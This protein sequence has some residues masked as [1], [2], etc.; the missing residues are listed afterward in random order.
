MLW[1]WLPVM[2]FEECWGSGM[3]L[4]TCWLRLIGWERSCCCRWLLRVGRRFA[5]AQHYLHSKDLNQNAN[6][7]HGNVLLPIKL[8]LYLEIWLYLWVQKSSYCLTIIFRCEC[9]RMSKIPLATDIMFSSKALENSSIQPKGL[10]WCYM[11]R[12]ILLR[13]TFHF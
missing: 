3:R 1:P 5:A 11:F 4:Y 2:G 6:R 9:W 10:L 8:Q 12:R 13:Q 7:E